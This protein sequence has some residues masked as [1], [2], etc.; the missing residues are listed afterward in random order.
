MRRALSPAWF[1]PLSRSSD[2]RSRGRTSRSSSTPRSNSAPDRATSCPETATLSK[3]RHG[4]S[5]TRSRTAGSRCKTFPAGCRRSVGCRRSS[6]ISTRRKPTPQD[7]VVQKRPHSRAGQIGLAQPLTHIRRTKLPAGTIL[8]RHRRR[9]SFSRKDVVSGRASSRRLPILAE[10]SRQVR[11]GREH[12]V[13]GSRYDSAACGSA[14]S[15][16]SG[17][18]PAPASIPV[19]RSRHRG[20]QDRTREPPALGT[21]RGRRTR[22]KVRRRR[23][24]VL[25]A[26]AA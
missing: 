1:W 8:T 16:A 5:F 17:T 15:P 6:S 23:A 12:D 4:S 20:G 24:T 19:Q 21:G 13:H 22:R 9:K 14:I 3:R 10:A 11:E 18:A 26:R 7:V 2:S 25:Q